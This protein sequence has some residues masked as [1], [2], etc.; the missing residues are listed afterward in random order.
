MNLIYSPT[1]VAQCEF[2]LFTYTDTA[3]WIPLYSP[4]QVVQYEFYISSRYNRA[5]YYGAQWIM[6]HQ[7]FIC[8]VQVE[9]FPL[10]IYLSGDLHI[11]FGQVLNFLNQWF[12]RLPC[13]IMFFAFQRLSKYFLSHVTFWDTIEA[14]LNM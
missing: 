3:E 8:K 9:E 6:Y 14:I 10:E 7:I 11:D 4:T 5:T 13:V 2:N 1:Q 12:G